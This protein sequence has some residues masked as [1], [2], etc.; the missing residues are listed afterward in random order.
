MLSGE[1]RAVAHD[2]QLVGGSDFDKRPKG[3]FAGPGPQSGEAVVEVDGGVVQ[4]RVH[5]GP[6]AAGVE[7][8][9]LLGLHPDDLAECASLIEV[10]Q[11]HGEA[12]GA[13]GGVAESCELHL[14]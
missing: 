13:V 6:V 9:K 5:L 11:A 7:V 1:G 12:I 2:V 14:A 4:L 10:E 3:L 8:D